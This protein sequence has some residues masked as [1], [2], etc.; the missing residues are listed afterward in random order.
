MKTQ[1]HTFLRIGL[2]PKR[3]M[4]MNGFLK[5]FPVLILSLLMGTLGAQTIMSLDDRLDDLPLEEAQH[6]QSLVQDNHPAIFL[7]N[8]GMQVFG[9]GDPVVAFCDA[10]SIGML[11]QSD[12]LFN[13]VELV[14]VLIPDAATTFT[15][16]LDELQ[17]FSSLEHVFA[18]FAY[19]ACGSYSETCLPG[20]LGGMIQG[21]ASTPVV[22]YELSIP[23]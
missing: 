13:Q 2:E 19:D 18:V 8:G 12:P 14:R 5:L 10:Q 11:Y 15:L 9:E 17:G 7:E 16:N 4:I 3:S 23:E 6:L 22:I 21:S 20:I 1:F